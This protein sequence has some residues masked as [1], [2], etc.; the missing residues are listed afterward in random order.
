MVGAPRAG[1]AP[2]AE[3]EEDDDQGEWSAEQPEK[4]EGH[5]CLLSM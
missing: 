2:D 4:D 5:D 3:Q 1:S